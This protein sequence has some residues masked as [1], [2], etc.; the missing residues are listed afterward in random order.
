MELAVRGGWDG[1]AGAAIGAVDAEDLSA[2][3][4]GGASLDCLGY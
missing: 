2:A 4:M 3:D 1:K